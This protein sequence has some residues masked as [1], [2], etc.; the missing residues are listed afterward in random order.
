M[1][2]GTLLAAT[3]LLWASTGRVAEAQSGPP[4]TGDGSQA[5]VATPPLA[6]GRTLADPG[7]ITG[8]DV[9][10]RVLLL[11]ENLGLLRKFMGAPQPARPLISGKDA[12]M[13]EAFFA[14]LSAKLRTAQLAFE[15]LRT[16]RPWRRPQLPERRIAASDVFRQVDTAL[17]IVLQ[18]KRSLGIAVEP[19][20]RAQ[21]DDTTATEL[22]NLLLSISGEVNGLLEEQIRS[23]EAYIL[24]TVLIHQAMTL[25]LKHADRMMPDEPPFEPNKTSEDVF[26]EFMACLQL[27]GRIAKTANVKFLSVERVADVDRSATPND[28]FDLGVL[29]IAELDAVILS[30]G[31]KRDYLTELAPS[32][33]FPSHV[34]QRARLLRPILTDVLVARSK[35][36]R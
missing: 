27:I 30:V 24:A 9:K 23:A 10:A 14:A 34:L 2:L 33:K 12:T 19:P 25:H 36:K 29:M 15:Q 4:P 6:S 7:K 20:E 1:K 8:G 16:E 11:K 22:F 3:V 18:V 28:L 32:R 5:L 26:A 13:R 17:A 35:A 31:R 21:P